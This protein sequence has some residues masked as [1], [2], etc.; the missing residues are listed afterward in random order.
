MRQVSPRALVFELGKR[1]GEEARSLCTLFADF[2][3]SVD[4]EGGGRK[5]IWTRQQLVMMGWVGQ[6]AV[7][8]SIPVGLAGAGWTP[9]GFGISRKPHNVITALLW[10]GRNY[11]GQILITSF[12]R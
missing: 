9:A 12:R 11:C 3:D 2:I 8:D 6:K 7:L 5:L 1:G 10:A 4:H